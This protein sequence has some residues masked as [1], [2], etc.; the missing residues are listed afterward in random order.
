[1]R[2]AVRDAGAH[3]IQVPLDD[4]AVVRDVRVRVQVLFQ[5]HVQILKHQVQLLVLM[6]HVL[7]TVFFVGVFL[8]F[9]WV[10]FGC[11]LGGIFFKSVVGG[12]WVGGEGGVVCVV[13][14]G[15]GSWRVW[16]REKKD[17]R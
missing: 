11:F 3:L 10:F 2:V 14:G 5:I 13:D 9:F 6:Y 16:G 12:W 15:G 1:M 7:Q 17:D 4:S 8:V